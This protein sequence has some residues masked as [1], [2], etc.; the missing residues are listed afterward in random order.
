MTL[1]KKALLEA[2]TKAVQD[3]SRSNLQMFQHDADRYAAQLI[4]QHGVVPELL[5]DIYFGTDA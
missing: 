1:S 4:N 5:D 2:F 3:Y